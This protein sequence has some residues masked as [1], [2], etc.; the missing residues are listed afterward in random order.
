MAKINKQGAKW[1]LRVWEKMRQTNKLFLL[2]LFP[3]LFFLFP[4]HLLTPAVTQNQIFP[5]PHFAAEASEN[6]EKKGER[7]TLTTKI[8]RSKV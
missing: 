2:I 5:L 4:F 6:G 8:A 3:F 1:T 7:R